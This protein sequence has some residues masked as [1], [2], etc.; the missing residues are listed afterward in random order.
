MSNLHN[1]AI[2]VCPS[3]ERSVAPP[4]KVEG[5]LVA[6]SATV[7][8]THLEA[9]EAAL[10]LA[11]ADGRKDLSMQLVEAA[12][13]VP[14]PLHV[15]HGPGEVATDHL[16]LAQSM[17]LNQQEQADIVWHDAELRGGVGGWE[18]GWCGVVWCGVVWCGVVRCGEVR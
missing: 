2:R 13:F 18:S 9:Q 12:L 5:P 4:T 1:A 14:T 7:V 3:G 6:K 15:V 17:F 16:T 10:A 11:F 8:F